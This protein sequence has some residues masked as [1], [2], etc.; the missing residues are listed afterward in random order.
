MAAVLPLQALQ[1]LPECTFLDKTDSVP[2]LSLSPGSSSSS[3]SHSSQSSDSS[4]SSSDAGSGESSVSSLGLVDELNAPFTP[5]QQLSI[6]SWDIAGFFLHRI[7]VLIIVLVL[8]TRR[9][10]DL[11]SQRISLAC[12]RLMVIRVMSAVSELI[13]GNIKWVSVRV[14]K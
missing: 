8:A 1:G 5:L 9:A 13:C 4:S 6:A 7:V 12:R 10:F 3:H 11:P 2:S 14:R